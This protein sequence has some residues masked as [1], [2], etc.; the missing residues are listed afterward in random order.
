MKIKITRKSFIGPGEDAYI[1]VERDIDEGD[2]DEI[3]SLFGIL[4]LS[5]GYPVGTVLSRFDCDWAYGVKIDDGYLDND[6]SEHSVRVEGNGEVS[7]DED[8]ECFCSES[9]TGVFSFIAAEEIK[10]GDLLSIDTD[11]GMVVVSSRK[12]K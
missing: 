5:M 11:T 4:L 2:I 6:G 12:E 3:V 9:P 7:V 10:P 8:E 1:S